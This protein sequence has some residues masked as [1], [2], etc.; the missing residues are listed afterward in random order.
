MSNTSIIWD[1]Y[2]SCTPKH[3]RLAHS[4]RTTRSW[5]C[6]LRSQAI[7]FRLLMSFKEKERKEIRELLMKMRRVLNQQRLKIFLLHGNVREYK[8]WLEVLFFRI[9]VVQTIQNIYTQD[10]NNVHTKFVNKKKRETV[11]YY[12]IPKN[13]NLARE[14]WPTWLFDG[15]CWTPV[16]WE[17]IYKL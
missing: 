17:H 16:G 4:A 13:R 3:W 1:D 10:V 6:L 14:D 12:T 2:I 11:G 9:T 5:W 8:V 7:T 15:E